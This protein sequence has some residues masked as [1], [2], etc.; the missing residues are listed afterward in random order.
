VGRGPIALL[1]GLIGFFAYLLIVLEVAARLAGSHW[2]VELLFFAVAG[3]V[4]AFP[5]ARLIK[6]V[7]EGRAGP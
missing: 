4:W 1:V 2:A 6:W 3:I 5:A 7:V